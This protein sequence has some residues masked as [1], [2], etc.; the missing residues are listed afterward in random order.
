MTDAI[1]ADLLISAGYETQILEFVDLSHTPKNLL[2]RAV[3]TNV[4]EKARKSALQ[5]VKQLMAEFHLKPTLYTLLYENRE[6]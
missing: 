1:R 3:R 4:G 6:A 2:L 5:E